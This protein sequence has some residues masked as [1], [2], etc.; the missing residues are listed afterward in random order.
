MKQFL[1]F[2][3]FIITILGTVASLIFTTLLAY[4]MFGF[5]GLGISFLSIFPI[6][7]YLIMPIL[8]KIDDKFDIF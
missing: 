8:D 3:L 1:G 7:L 4:A 5:L 6:L 2:Y